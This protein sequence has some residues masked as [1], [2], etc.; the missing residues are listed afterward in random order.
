[1]SYE[2]KPHL[3]YFKVWGCLAKV[4][5]PLNENWKNPLLFWLNFLILLWDLDMF[6][7]NDKLTKFVCYTSSIAL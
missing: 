6:P 5:I 2:K 7:S 1:M 4:S 3:K